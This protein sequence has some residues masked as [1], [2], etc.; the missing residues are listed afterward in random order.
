MAQWL[1][2]KYTVYDSTR[3]EQLPS[4]FMVVMWVVSVLWIEQLAAMFKLGL[5]CM[6][7]RY[8]I[9]SVSVSVAWRVEKFTLGYSCVTLRW[10]SR[11]R[12]S[13][14][15]RTYGAWCMVRLCGIE[16]LGRQI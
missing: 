6:P 8:G 5:G 16:I 4:R 10:Y 15:K 13:T 7:V 2:F 9:L 3:R 11:H 1:V 12:P 14:E